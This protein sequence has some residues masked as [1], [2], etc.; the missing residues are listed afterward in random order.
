ML[1]LPTFAAHRYLP[2][3][4]PTFLPP[5]YA[6]HRSFSKHPRG[7]RFF[8]FYTRV[9]PG[10]GVTL[11]RGSGLL[12]WRHHAYSDAAHDPQSPHNSATAF[13]PV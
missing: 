9:G 1:V 10:A 7:G 8:F 6:T 11:P 4:A 5:G 3:V 13:D 2:L 12:P